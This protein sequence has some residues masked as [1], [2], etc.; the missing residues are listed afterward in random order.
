MALSLRS[1]R[2][3]PASASELTPVSSL[4]QNRHVAQALA[5]IDRYGA[6]TT[7]QQIFLTEIPA[8]TLQE[9]ARGEAV[10][11]LFAAGG[12]RTRVD[13][14]GNVLGER[15]GASRKDVVLLSAHLDTVFP[16]GT[17]IKVQRDGRRL[18]APGISD[19]GAGLAALVCLA[20]A[21][22]ESKLRTQYTLLFTANAAEEGEGNLRGMRKLVETLRGRLR[23]VI[24]VDGAATDHITTMALASRRL[25]VTLSG[26]GGHSWADF[27]MPNPVHALARGIQKFLAVRLPEN[28]R[29]TFNV[30]VIHGGT[31]VNT[32]AGLATAKVD[33]RSETEAELDRLEA[34]LRKAVESGVAEEMAAAAE[35]GHSSDPRIEIS[36]RGLGD[37]PGGELPEDSPLLEAIRQADRHLNNQSRLERSSTDANIPLS[38]GIPAIAVGGG[39]R[40]AG[41]HSP[42]EWYDPTGRELGL[43]RILL[44]ALAISGIET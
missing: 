30:G 41:A 40:S 11:K 43:K 38:M 25:E 9:A 29:T 17:R 13:A 7:E 39:G 24:A 3:T 18:S 5:A 35:S 33:I 2:P 44:T 20:R 12:L 8:P 15:P 21:L 27:G 1:P 22:H 42:G 4:V 19:N 32:I 28:P 16:P 26:P 31:S 10:R 36:Y 14:A 37:R 6:W 34:A 23:A